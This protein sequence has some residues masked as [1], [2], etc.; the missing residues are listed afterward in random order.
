ME[1]DVD[2]SHSVIE[3]SVF[4]P[5]T[6]QAFGSYSNKYKLILTLNYRWSWW[7]KFI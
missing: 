7:G 3:E 2:A 6:D 5:E 4:I 1:A